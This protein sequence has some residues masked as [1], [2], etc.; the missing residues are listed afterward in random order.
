MKAIKDVRYFAGV[1]HVPHMIFE[2]LA[3]ARVSE[4]R[5]EMWNEGQ[6]VKSLLRATTAVIAWFV[7]IGAL[8][9]GHVWPNKAAAGLL[10]AIMLDCFNP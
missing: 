9:E 6:V 10:A 1:R 7:A 3:H 5:L 4:K 2:L 8:V